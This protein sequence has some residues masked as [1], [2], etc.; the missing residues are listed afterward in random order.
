MKMNERKENAGKI[1][2]KKKTPRM[3]KMICKLS[4]HSFKSCFLFAAGYGKEAQGVPALPS[5]GVFCRHQVHL[6]KQSYFYL[7]VKQS[8]KCRVMHSTRATTPLVCS[9]THRGKAH[10]LHPRDF[11]EF[12]TKSQFQTLP[13]PIANCSQKFSYGCT[14]MV[15]SR[16]SQISVG[17]KKASESP[18]Y[19]HDSH[20]PG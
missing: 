11:H 6:S 16:F 10:K 9:V 19:S 4:P 18:K 13:L 20:F 17:G 15:K 2:G 3:L 8:H 5:S 7:P 1:A 12:V 14:N